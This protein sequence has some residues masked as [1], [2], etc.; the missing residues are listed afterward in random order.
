MAIIQEKDK[1][2]IKG[3]IKDLKNKV[4]IINF[5]QEMECQYCRETRQLLEELA[6]LSDKIEIK[7]YNF[8][9]D[10]E[11]AEKYKIDKIP[12]TILM[13]E[14]DYG[15][16]FYGIPAGYEF[17]GMLEMIQNISNGKSGLNNG[18]VEKLKK[19]TEPMRMQVFV[20]PTCPYCPNVAKAAMQFAME[21]DN[22]KGE[23]VEI[24]E[25]PH[26]AN[27]YNIRGVPK[28]VVNENIELE[29]MMPEFRLIDEII[30]S[31]E[32]K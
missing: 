13:G 17:A 10:R 16:R 11:I 9:T 24:G 27:K 21:N 31:L 20:T 3:Q 5:T 19:I 28:T 23:V 12:A 22:I 6:E 14:K 4:A 15:I 18:T 25:F 29:G 30:K 26:L 8:Q 7:V 2:A 32:I 1:E